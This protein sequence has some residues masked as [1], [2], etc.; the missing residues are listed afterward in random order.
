[1]TTHPDD[2][3]MQ[4]E[5]PP[6]GLAPALA[7]LWW[8]RKGAFRTGPAWERAHEICQAAE[9]EPG[10]DLVHGLAHLVEGDLFNADYWYGRAG[11][12]RL[13]RL[14]EEEWSN[15]CRALLEAGRAR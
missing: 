11:T 3:D 13:S 2:W 1:M 12:P 10:H 7:A 6:D 8:L 9:G 5:A 4:A 14:P 15:V